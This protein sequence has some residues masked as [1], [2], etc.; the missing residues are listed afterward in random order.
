MEHSNLS[1]E[2]SIAKLIVQIAKK[3]IAVNKELQETQN[4]ETERFQTLSLLLK[5]IKLVKN[6]FQNDHIN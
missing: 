2:D 4:E 5:S 6:T 3:L 1:K